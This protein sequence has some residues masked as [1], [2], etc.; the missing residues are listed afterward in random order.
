MTIAGNISLQG[1]SL[2]Q[3]KEEK[4]DKYTEP[5]TEPTTSCKACPVRKKES[6]KSD[7]S[8]VNSTQI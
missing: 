4:V 3:N 7:Q 6:V 5:R 1:S 2:K 8:T